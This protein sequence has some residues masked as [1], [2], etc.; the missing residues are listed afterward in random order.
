MTEHPRSGPRVPAR[1]RTSATGGPS[2]ATPSPQPLSERTLSLHAPRVQ[3]PSY[4][5]SALTPAVVHFS[6][7][8]FHRAHQLVYFDDLAELGETGWGV[9]GVG[10]RSSAMRDALRPQDHLYTV[11]ERSRDGE[12]ARIVG[13]MLDYHFAPEAP[14]AVLAALT[15]DRTRLVTMTVTGTAYRVDPRT[16]EFDPDDDDVR[17]D[18]DDPHHPRSLFGYIVEGLDRRRRAGQPPFTVLSCDNMQQNGEAAR[19]AVVGFARLRDEV[20]AR[21]I[22]DSVAFPGSMVDRITPST[23]LED[24]DDV[25]RRFGVA[26][27][28]PVITEPFTQWVME[29]QFCNGRPPLEDVGVQF[30]PDVSAYELMK[31]R[32]LNAG[33]SALGHLGHLAGHVRMDEV[34]ADPDL[35]E[36]VTRLMAEEVA[37]LLPVPDGIDLDRYQRSL[38]QR[39]A[40][41]AIADRLERLCRR[42]SSKVPL[43]VL[44]SLRE[45]L[46]AGRRTELLTLAVAGFC[47]YLRGTDLQGREFPLQDERAEELRTLAVAG[48]TDPRPLLGVRAVFGDLGDRPE[49]VASLTAALQQLDRDGV[50][51]TLAATLDAAGAPHAGAVVAAAGRRGR[52]PSGRRTPDTAVAGPPAAVA[53]NALLP[54]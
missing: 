27:N 15:D 2:A 30:V 32:L 50:R 37:P 19:A 22:A 38:L 5:R 45:A 14:D 41:P 7:G 36:Y 25:A 42:G 12:R 9:I 31:T 34:M 6:V 33:H 47:R 46:D 3:V 21:W 23:S 1:A 8:G 29:D 4:D 26:D 39:F 13:S 40:D 44:P 49:F 18:L 11:V 52:A 17:A 24:R 43:Y 10:L 51:A 35:G 53:G 48:G 16:G 54:A 20:L 28:W